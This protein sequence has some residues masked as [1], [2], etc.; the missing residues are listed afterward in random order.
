[1]TT[2]AKTRY[3]DGNNQ[4]TKDI[5]MSE[6]LDKWISTADAS[7]IMGITQQ[8]VQRLC[9]KGR[10]ECQKFGRD[11]MVSSEDAQNYEFNVGGRGKK[12]GDNL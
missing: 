5:A 10:I 6:Q 7:E 1:M 9:R 4:Y 8:A 3:A 11:W 12:S 2:Q